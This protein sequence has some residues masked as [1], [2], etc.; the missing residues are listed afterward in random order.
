[1][2]RGM[3]RGLLVSLF[4][5]FSIYSA[6]QLTVFIHGTVGLA[7]QSLSLA[8]LWKGSL[9]DQ[10]Y[11]LRYATAF[12]NDPLMCEDQP[13]L[14]EGLVFIDAT[15][16]APQANYA[17]Y[18][19]ISA[20]D[21]LCTTS[22]KRSYAVFGWSGALS[23]KYRQKAGYDLYDALVAYRDEC[24]KTSGEAPEITLVCHS[25]GGTVALWLADAEA[26]NHK[27]LSIKTVCMLGTPLHEEVKHLLESELFKN[28]LLISSHGDAIQGRDYFSTATR[29]S[30][31]KIADLINLTTF[32][33]VHPDCSRHDVTVQV[34]SDAK[35]IDHMNMWFMGKST[36]ICSQL[37][38]FPLSVMMPCIITASEK[39]GKTAYMRACIHEQNKQCTVHYSVC[40]GGR[41]VPCE[42]SQ[43][44]CSQLHGIHQSAQTNWKPFDQSRSVFVN[45]KNIQILKN[46]MSAK[47]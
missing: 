39:I 43:D 1:M 44:I 2:F 42:T 9:T 41:L 11:G 8:S 13:L 30:Y 5:S 28:I 35:R 6:E 47:S 31:T 19:I 20:Y 12:R 26:H 18:Y 29:K 17:A 27:N 25:H 23:Q 34:H 4:F 16:P 32:A 45:K 38:L 46:I 21:A 14:Q 33:T 10:H 15:L 3:G 40:V 37:P 24:I 36:I 22:H 7:L